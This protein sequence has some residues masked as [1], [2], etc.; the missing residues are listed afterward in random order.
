MAVLRSPVARPACLLAAALGLASLP[1]ARPEGSA[2]RAEGPTAPGPAPTAAPKG[3]AASAYFKGKVV[4]QKGRRIELSY[5]FADPAQAGDWTPAHPFLE[6]PTSGGW[7]VEGGALRADG[8]G[9]FRHR[10]V[11]HGD[12]RIR[13]TLSCEDARNYGALVIDAEGATFDLFAL[14]DA[15][16]S[17]KDRRLGHE[18]MIT[19]FLPPGSGAG[20]ATAWRYVQTGRDPRLTGEAI[21]ID[22][23][24]RGAM[25]E[26][27]FAGTGRLSG[28]DVEAK[29]G[30]RMWPAFYT[31]GSRVVVDDATISGALDAAWL[32]QE[33]IEFDEKAPEE[34][35]PEDPAPTPA[36]GPGA[37]GAP[38]VPP[39]VAPG[40][41]W[42][43][44]AE[45]VADAGA[46]RGE[47]EA[48]ANAIIASKERRAAR[49]MIDLL[50]ADDD[51][52]GRDLGIKV[53]RALV[54]KD[55]GYNAAAQPDDRKKSMPAVWKAW[56]PVR[57]AL[58]KEDKAKASKEKN[59]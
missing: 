50:Y 18:H 49:R 5:D 30:P 36:A 45:K 21:K 17:I 19:T 54:G 16:F 14:A 42:I 9:A 11:F 55:G 57:D 25:N 4:S 48:A 56:Y 35:P 59:G 53:F 32:R 22:V 44:F 1:V 15:F 40:T 12:V 2:A 7:R 38:P 58:E 23:R 29:V 46:S 52:T 27:L 13:A 43:R 6:P 31:L 34:P 28:N 26:F 39:A 24:K 33:G 51:A 8:N 47:R 37:P 10:A 3:V 41:D 20:G